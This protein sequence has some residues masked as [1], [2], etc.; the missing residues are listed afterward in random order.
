M[1]KYNH[2]NIYQWSM[3]IIWILLP[4]WCVLLLHSGC[5]TLPTNT[6]VEKQKPNIEQIIATT[7]MQLIVEEQGI[8]L[9]DITKSSDVNYST[10]R[11]R[12]LDNVDRL[13]GRLKEMFDMLAES[14]APAK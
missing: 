7:Q 2:Y 13:R 1:I 9:L 4:I 3:C 11:K 10:E 5:T 8:L 14:Y 12:R 6:I